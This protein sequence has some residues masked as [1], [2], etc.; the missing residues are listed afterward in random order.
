MCRIY[1]TDSKVRKKKQESQEKLGEGE[2]AEEEK[3]L[4]LPDIKIYYKTTII[5]M[6][7]YSS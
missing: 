4:A 3:G 1:H 6:V 5:M 7:R 2:K